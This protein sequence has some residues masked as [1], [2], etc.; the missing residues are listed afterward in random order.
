MNSLV[1]KMHVEPC[2]FGGFCVWL[3]KVR[4]ALFAGIAALSKA[5]Q[6]SFVYLQGNRASNIDVCSFVA[7]EAD[8]VYRKRRSEEI[9]LA[10]IE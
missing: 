4:T 3:L 10:A 1:Q 6:M 2:I 7:Q 8:N 9:W 5:E